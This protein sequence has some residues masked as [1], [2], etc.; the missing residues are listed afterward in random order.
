M[1]VLGGLSRLWGAALGGLVFGYLQL[2]LPGLARSGVFDPL[3]GWLEGPLTEP[4]AWALMG[5]G[6]I[7]GM[8]WILWGDTSE[9]P[10]DVFDEALG[11]VLRGLGTTTEDTLGRGA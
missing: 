7:I 8:R 6:E 10:P 5:I 9:V 4:L 2:R 3:P 11:F 1:V